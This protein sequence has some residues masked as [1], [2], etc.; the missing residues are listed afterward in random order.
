MKQR[1]ITK[2]VVLTIQEFWSDRE[3]ADLTRVGEEALI[4][5]THALILAPPPTFFGGMFMHPPCVSRVFC[6]A[7]VN[8]DEFDTVIVIATLIP[9]LLSATTTFCL[10]ISALSPIKLTAQQSDI[11][12]HTYTI[13]I[14]NQNNEKSKIGRNPFEE[15]KVLNQY[16]KALRVYR[17]TSA[18]EADERKKIKETGRSRE[19]SVL[20]AQ[21]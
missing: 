4:E 16:L 19:C 2:L 15:I 3:A 1:L 14:V 9:D 12:N 18:G 8:R 21:L 5:S 7:F 20:K 6:T 10:V 11:F 17:E 13:F